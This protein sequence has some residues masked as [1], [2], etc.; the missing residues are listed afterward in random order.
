MKRN[1]TALGTGALALAGIGIVGGGALL[2]KNRPRQVEIAIPQRKLVVE[3]ISASG[4]LRGEVE[5]SVGAATGGRVIALLVKEGQ[6][7]QKGQL[8]AQLDNQVLE[9]QRAQSRSQLRTFQEQLAQAQSSVRTAQAQLQQAKRGPLTDDVTRLKADVAQN[10]AIAEAKVASSKSRLTGAQQKL[11]AAQQRLAELKAGSR[12]EEVEQAEAQ[13]R[14]SE[15]N[16][17]QAKRD[18]ERQSELL[19]A[20]AIARNQAEQAQTQLAVAEQTLESHRARLRQLKN[21]TRPEQ[22][23]QAEADVAAAEAEVRTASSEVTSA[24]ASRTGAAQSGQA[25]IRSLLSSPRP[26]D[27][28]VAEARLEEAR[29]AESTARQRLSEATEGLG[30]SEKRLQETRLLAPF[31]GIVT[32]IITEEGGIISPTSSLLKLT[33]LQKPEIKIDVDEV[34]LGRLRLG[35]T[36]EVTSEAYAGQ[37]FP[38]RVTQVGTQVDTDRGTVEVRLSPLNPPS[39]I[40]SGQTL[41]VNLILEA[42]K[43]KLVVP[44]AAVNTVGDRSTALVIENGRVAR[45]NVKVG[46]AS[47]QLLP[48]QDGLSESDRVILG[49]SD[50]KEGQLVVAKEKNHR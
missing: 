26:E 4:R 45:R 35:Q 7:V 48:I 38:A 46:A 20:R 12:L 6:R 25:Q 18:N 37:S 17:T 15:A 42:G 39:W 14:Q 36:A 33:R 30:L 27:V 2:A 9:A 13:V 43:E 31:D 16:L 47:A 40:R 34:N 44:V 21:G 50:L 8:L 10:I 41:S 11:L 32:Q 28:A 24:Q 19:A 22:L 5:T 3:S 29:R 49:G 23:R 1:V